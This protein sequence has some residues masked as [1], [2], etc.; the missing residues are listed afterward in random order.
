[1][2]WLMVRVEGVSA[3]LG[4]LPLWW[5]L[6]KEI[7]LAAQLTNEKRQLAWRLRKDG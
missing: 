4:E 5:Q 2:R 1:M 7:Q 3:T 6:T